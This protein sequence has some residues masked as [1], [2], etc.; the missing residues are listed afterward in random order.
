MKTFPY[1]I[2]PINKWSM[3]LF[4]LLTTLTSCLE[5]EKL[6]IVKMGTPVLTSSTSKI[7]LSQKQESNTVLTLSWT[8]GN[9]EGTNKA[10][11]YVVQIDKKGNNFT[12][13]VEIELG[14]AIY[15]SQF[16]VSNFND[17]LLNSLL[18]TAGEEVTLEFRVVSQTKDATVEPDFSNVI[19]V[20][21]TP[22][23]PVFVPENLYLVGDATPNGWNA[24]AATPM[25][26]NNN[27]HSVFTW[28]G[29]LNA[30]EFK[31]LTILDNWIPS[32]QKGANDN[33]LVLRTDFGQP[34]DKFAIAS[35][36]SYT[37]TVD[38]IA[39]TISIEALESS[40]YNELWIVGDATPKGWNIDGA[41][42]MKQNP[43]DPFVFSFNAMLNVGEFKIA[44]AKN[45]SALFYRPLSQHPAIT[46]TTVQ[47]SAGDPDNKWYIENAG[48]Y[49]ITLDLRQ[50]T[51]NIVP[52]TAYTNLW[53]IGDAGPNGWNIDSPSVT[54]TVDPENA[55]VY[56]YTGNLN[57]GEFKIALG[58]GNWCGNW[59]R[60]FTNAPALTDTGL[61]FNSGCEVDNKWKITT[62]GTYKVTVDQLNET[63]TFVAQ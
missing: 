36:G 40:P 14:K 20:M 56:T 61:V 34:D 9:N 11:D 37:V 26:R 43:S 32:Y 52:F 62:A 50:N 3:L 51:I 45:W 22:Y 24:G 7:V 8:P 23:E 21:V 35:K 13:P 17:L 18:L 54:M 6:E 44:T 4:C 49:K 31:F 1:K 15:K 53:M 47:L 25:I 19:E 60:P 16:Q 12:A 48:A 10:I 28:Q 27:D 59:I 2:N 5:E 30:G 57:I 29:T 39:L 63:I 58:T 41:D 55:N 46:E 33:T 42:P 38:L